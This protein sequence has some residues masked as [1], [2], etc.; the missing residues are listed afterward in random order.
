MLR[1][2]RNKTIYYKRVAISNCGFDLQS[3]LGSIISDTG[4]APKVGMRREQI[5]PS[6]STSGFRLINRSNNYKS[7]LFGQL[8]LFEQGKSQALLTISD[9]VDFYD[10]NA[11]TSQQIKLEADE[12]ISQ[13]EKEK[14]KREFVDSILY[15]G[16]QGNDL[17]MVQSNSLRS[18]D[19]ETHLNWL[20]HNFSDSFNDDSIL[21]LKDKPTES[22]IERLENTPVKKINIGSVPVKNKVDNNTIEIKNEVNPV[23]NNNSQIKKIKFMPTGK[24]GNILK[25]AFGE[26]WFSELR[27]EDSLDDSNIQINL[28]ITYLRKTDK[29]GQRLMDTLATS[30]RH[31]DDDDIEISLQGGGTIKG[32]E[33][34]LSG[35]IS[36]QHND[37]LIDENHL[38]LQMHKWLHSKIGAGEIKPK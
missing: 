16:V 12:G 2:N 37:G 17:V 38:Y 18:K 7:I 35:S 9:D 11:I 3:I 33:L 1:Q 5:S 13:E 36:I 15:F 31:S 26:N 6:D 21:L 8:I 10:I 29:D 30:L 23:N 32:G 20:I 22:T 14:I 34:K 25:A 28:E 19:L 27:L 4:T 24:G